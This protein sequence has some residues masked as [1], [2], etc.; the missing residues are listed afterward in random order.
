VLHVCL[1]SEI[2]VLERSRRL[3]VLWKS[4]ELEEQQKIELGS[5]TRI[6][7]QGLTKMVITLSS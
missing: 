1:S 3:W 7:G 6:L 5:Q 4:A 2:R